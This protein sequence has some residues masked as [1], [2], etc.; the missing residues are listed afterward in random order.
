MGF[1]FCI[2]FIMSN[3]VMVHGLIFSGELASQ[4]ELAKRFPVTKE[5][6]YKYDRLI[7]IDEKLSFVKLQIIKIGYPILWGALS[8]VFLLIGIKSRTNNCVS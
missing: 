3:E 4:A 5:Q 7:F 2:V 1:A 6:L 8:F